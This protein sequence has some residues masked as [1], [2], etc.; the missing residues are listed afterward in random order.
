MY[1]GGPTIQAEC[2]DFVK[3][4]GALLECTLHITKAGTLPF[5]GIL[6]TAC[7]KWDSGSKREIASLQ[8][9]IDEI[10][11]KSEE[12]KFKSLAMPLVCL[13]NVRSLLDQAT[14]L[15]VS[16]ILEFYSA[17]N[18]TFSIKEIFLVDISDQVCFAEIIFFL[19]RN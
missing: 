7:P 18:K 5:K 12:K 8:E 10:L 16:S 2:S 4:H 1:I 11:A 17:K 13:G 6:H 14:L 19:R 3:Y 9:T 15:I